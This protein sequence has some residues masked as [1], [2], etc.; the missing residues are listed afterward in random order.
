MAMEW[1]YLVNNQP[2]GPVELD[3]LR[4]RMR[5]GALT[6]A[7]LVFGPGLSDWTPAGRVPGLFATGGNAGAAQALGNMAAGYA[8]SSS[9]GGMLGYRGIDTGTSGLSTIAA[10]MLRETKPWTRFIAVVTFVMAGLMLLGGLVFLVMV[11]SM[12]SRSRSDVP[13][14]M[15]IVYIGLGALYFAPAIFLN[16][17]ASKIGDV[18]RTNGM[19]DLEQALAAQK[20]FWK[21]AG[22]MMIILLIIYGIVILMAVSG[23]MRF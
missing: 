12:G 19:R 2:V 20:S 9:G 14:L 1:H 7:D 13:A 3:L 22:I 8:G 17:Y 23:N 10:N 4:D 11:S 6:A 5:T 21:F 18:L 16:R 15:G